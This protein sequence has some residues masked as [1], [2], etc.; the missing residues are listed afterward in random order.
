MEVLKDI[1]DVMA[2]L[3]G[4][5]SA[6]L[7]VFTAALGVYTYFRDSKRKL[8]NE[9]MAEYKRLQEEVFDKLND[10]TSAE[11]VAEAADSPGTYG[12]T[13]LDN[14]LARIEHF[15][16]GL[17][18]GVYDFETFYQLS[19]G[20]FDYKLQRL[21]EPL[22][23]K[24]LNEYDGGEDYYNNLHKVWKRMAERSEKEL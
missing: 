1:L 18:R 14:A 21:F 11:Q 23:D 20:Y 9:T 8:C 4:I 13:E 2:K 16:V 10:W 19:H 6:V 12:H 24:K 3:I 22:L 17:N 5:P 15:C 7:G